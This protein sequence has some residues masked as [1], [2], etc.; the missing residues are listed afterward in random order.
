[1]SYNRTGAVVSQLCD[2]LIYCHQRNVIHRDLKPE[3]VMI[4]DQPFGVKLGDFGWAVH[5][6]S[7]A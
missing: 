6:P 4:V 7:S 2:A 1:M 5:A 3:N